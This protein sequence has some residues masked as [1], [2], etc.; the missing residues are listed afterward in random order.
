ML[1]PAFHRRKQDAGSVRRLIAGELQLGLS[2]C[3]GMALAFKRNPTD[4]VQRR[5]MHRFDYRIRKWSNDSRNYGSK[6]SIGI[7]FNDT[8]SPAQPALKYWSMPDRGL[9][10]ERHPHSHICSFYCQRHE[11]LFLYES[12]N[13]YERIY[14]CVH[15]TGYRNWFRRHR[16][17]MRLLMLQNKSGQQSLEEDYAWLFGAMVHWALRLP[18]SL[19]CWL[20]WNQGVNR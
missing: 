6:Q 16:L 8:A 4:D 20:D 19:A 18:N 14:Y 3:V 12:N 13:H 2:K 7:Y 10:A 9:K 11:F 1:M 5:Y 17:Q 15:T